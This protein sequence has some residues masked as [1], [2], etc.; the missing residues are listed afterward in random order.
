MIIAAAVACFVLAAKWPKQFVLLG[1]LV[2]VFSDTIVLH[3][4][5]EQASLL[6]EA[7]VSFAL[8][9]FPIKRLASGR[10]LRVMNEFSWLG[11]VVVAGIAGSIIHA[12]PPTVAAL[13]GI[14]LL[15]W[16]LLSYAVAQ[17]DWNPQ[18][19]RV[20]LRAGSI[21]AVAVLSM[22]F[23]N[24]L[25][26]ESW[27]ATFSGTGRADNRFGQASLIGPF[28]HPSTFASVTALIAIAAAAYNSVVKRRWGA[29]LLLVA[30]VV[31]SVLAFRRRLWVALGTGLASIWVRGRSRVGF[32]IAVVLILPI[33]AVVS[34]DFFGGVVARI[35]SDYLTDA[36]ELATARTVMT[37]DAF[38]IAAASFPFGVGL[39]RFGSYTAALFYS[40]E[41]VARG[42][43]FIY[44]LS[45][46]GHGSGAFL[47]DTFW[48]SLIG[49]TGWSGAIAFGLA[50]F[51]SWNRFRR[52]QRHRFE[53]H[54]RWVG[55]AGAGALLFFLVD[56]IASPAF[57]AVLASILFSIVGVAVSLDSRGPGSPVSSP[58]QELVP[59]RR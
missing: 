30:S 8:T 1:V 38:S 56:S 28:T 32:V 19:I 4:G 44:G 55:T 29:S 2:S 33:V 10:P 24:L 9:V 42:Y 16:F 12:V 51:C 25:A 45:P 58:E 35:A 18:D 31:F 41:Y 37:V 52:L 39:G 13:G 6:D 48:P 49:E 11:L 17:V 47:T 20:A 34:G 26:P 15:K 43:S 5:L 50:L 14:L 57:T 22:G 27:T 40:P 7:F 3:T 46:E 21:I 54:V 23:V 53:A 36:A 59:V